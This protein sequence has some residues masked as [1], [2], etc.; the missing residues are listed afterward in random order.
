[1]TTV[2]K[3]TETTPKT[4]GEASVLPEGQ[5]SQTFGDYLITDED[6]NP[7]IQNEPEESQKTKE[8][9][10]MP[11]SGPGQKEEKPGSIGLF[12]LLSTKNLSGGIRIT[13]DAMEVPQ[14]GC[15]VRTVIVDSRKASVTSVWI[16]GVRIIP[17]VVDDKIVGNRLWG[18]DIQAMGID[19]VGNQLD[20]QLSGGGF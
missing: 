6:G 15:F 18:K 10:S 5:E 17:H 3:T 9:P 4:L 13:T 7:Y 20:R 8:Y 1:M 12:K 2:E 11:E 19:S 14:M 16:P